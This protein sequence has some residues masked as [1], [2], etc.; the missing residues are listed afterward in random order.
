[1]KSAEL[2]A[3][4][5]TAEGLKDV[6]RHAYTSRRRHESV[7]E[8]SWRLALMAFFLRDEFPELDM[9]KVIRMGLIH[10]L[11]EIFTGDIPTFL[12][13]DADTKTE[14]DLLARWVATLPAP[15]C[16]E[17][18]A[19]Y[20]EMNALRTPEAKL[21]KSLDKLEA[22]IQHNESPLDTWSD[23]EYSLNL[24]YATDTVAWSEYLTALRAAIREETE[25]K[26]TKEKT[27]L[28]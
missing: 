10:D 12:K 6:T 28:A 22:V 3:I 15:Y 24:T 20:E 16:D 17:M 4:L 26:I 1:M 5:H 23:N 25:S 21:Y 19:L 13:T 2:L 18:A 11:G 8:H 7:A 27:S 14:D 9:D